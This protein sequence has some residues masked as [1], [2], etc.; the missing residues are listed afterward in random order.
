MMLMRSALYQTN[1][2]SWILRVLNIAHWNDSPWIDMSPH[3]NT[4]A[5]FRANQYLFFLLNDV[6]GEATNTNF[7][8]F[9]LTRSGLV[10]TIYHTRGEHANHYTTDGVT[11]N[12]II[13]SV[14]DEGFCGVHYIRYLRDLLQ[15]LYPIFL[16]KHVFITNRFK[17]KSVIQYCMSVKFFF[18]YIIFLFNGMILQQYRL[19]DISY[20]HWKTEWIYVIKMLL[21]V[22]YVTF[23]CSHIGSWK[24]V[25]YIWCILVFIYTIIYP[26]DKNTHTEK[27][28]FYYKALGI[29]CLAKYQKFYVLLSDKKFEMNVRNTKIQITWNT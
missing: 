7:I 19:P 9:G 14:H 13:L 16:R 12:L 21:G 25:K 28:Y 17:S 1:T 5:W 18:F 24:D 20:L 15:Q 11:H 4:L 29:R 10:P 27:G 23:S 6:C 22:I 2:L 8:V 3:E 26:K